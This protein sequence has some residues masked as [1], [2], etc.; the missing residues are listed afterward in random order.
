[1]TTFFKGLAL[2][3]AVS[4]LAWISVLWHW[5]TSAH[6]PSTNDMLAYLVLL[7]LAGFGLVLLL[8]WGWRTAAEWRA[9]SAASAAAA[10]AAQAEAAATKAPPPEPPAP[11][12]QVLRAELRCACAEDVDALLRAAQAGK[13]L[14]VL[15]EEL[16]HD[17]G[18]PIMS[19]RI[20]ELPLDDTQALLESLASKISGQMG[21]ASA[22]PSSAQPE[23]QADGPS[24]TPSGG[25][26]V[27]ADPPAYDGP[28]LPAHMVRAL[29]ALAAPLAKALQGLQPWWPLFDPGQQQPKQPERGVDLLLAWPATWPAADRALADAWVRAQLETASLGPIAHQSV[30]VDSLAI[31]GVELWVEAQRRLREQRREGRQRALLL[32]S[33]HSDLSEAAVAAL[34]RER[35]LF[36]PAQHPKGLMPAEGAAALLL[37][38]HDWPAAPDAPD[39]PVRLH[40]AAALQRDKSIE[41]AGSVSSQTLVDALA[42]AIQLAK[43]EPVNIAK[44]V[45]DADRHSQRGT[46][47]FGAT[48]KVLPQLDAAEDLCLTAAVAGHGNAGALMVLAGAAARAAAEKKPCVGLALGDTHWRLA[49]V[50]VPPPPPAA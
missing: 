1:M 3:V 39:A 20:A 46:E 17:D 27:D 26:P 21:G 9:S 4:C 23:R 47:L 48:L 29:A 35:R 18:L 44:L 2:L 24:G 6:S 37:A 36:T 19:V 41:A 28:E 10:Q 5:R 25:A 7:P 30:G 22:D 43:L 15:D 45:C 13:P 49:V 8:R 38:P 14:P 31:G 50:A 33:A 34:A 16:C 42:G 12:L 11:P 32:A 40:P